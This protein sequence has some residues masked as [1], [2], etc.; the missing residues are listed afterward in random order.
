M[1]NQDTTIS[2]QL[3]RQIRIRD[4]QRQWR[5]VSSLRLV[6]FNQLWNETA[7]EKREWKDFNESK[8]Y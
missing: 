3:A 8:N 2:G 7:Q 1:D 5:R 6:E 4:I